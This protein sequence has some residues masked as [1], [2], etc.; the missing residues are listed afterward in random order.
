MRLKSRFDVQA[1]MKQKNLT[2]TK[3]ANQLDINIVSLY[4]AISG[5]MTSQRIIKYLE[6]VF[7]TPIQEITNAWNQKE[8]A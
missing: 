7:E 3:M 1:K 6:D 5:R 4:Q 8:V 2:P